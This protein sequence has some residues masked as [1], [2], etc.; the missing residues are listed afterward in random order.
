VLSAISHP[1]PLRWEAAF[2]AANVA[3]FSALGAALSLRGWEL[4]GVRGLL[5]PACLALQRVVA[6]LAHAGGGL[7]SPGGHQYLLVYLHM[8][9]AAL[10]PISN[11][12]LRYS[13]PQADA[14]VRDDAVRAIAQR[15]DYAFLRDDGTSGTPKGLKNW[16]DAANKFSANGTVS[17]A[18][19]TSDLGKAMQLIMDANITLIIQQAATGG[20]DV[21]PGWIFSPRQWKYLTT[22]QTTVGN[23]AFRDEMLR[24]TLWGY[25]FAVTT[26]IPITLNTNKSEVYFADFA[27]A[28]F[29]DLDE[30]TPDDRLISLV[31]TLSIQ[32]SRNR[33]SAADG[34][35]G[36]GV[37]GFDCAT[38]SEITP[39]PM[40]NGRCVSYATS[41]NS[42]LSIDNAGNLSNLES[43]YEYRNRR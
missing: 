25:P 7:C 5:R 22:V 23:Y 37:P 38:M 18:N 27:D 24:G 1:L 41:A 19:V 29:P 13:S 6:P 16:I 26:N 42:P 35:P 15:E 31:S 2:G 14:I 12:L 21:R 43:S 34:L 20:V 3:L 40:S 11:D 8:L 30:A 17:L 10:V 33:S 28:S 32:R 4:M 9:L 39:H 36:A